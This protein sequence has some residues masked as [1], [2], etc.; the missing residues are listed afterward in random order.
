VSCP[1][2]SRGTPPPFCT[3]IVYFQLLTGDPLY[4]D[5][6]FSIVCAVSG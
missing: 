4:G 2:S 6:L 1:D 3:E 5:R